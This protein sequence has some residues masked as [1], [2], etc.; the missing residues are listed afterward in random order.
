M[1][2]LEPLAFLDLA[3]SAK[4]KRKQVCEIIKLLHISSILHG[5]YWL[6]RHAE[7]SAQIRSLNGR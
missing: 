5:A 7:L 1:I 4:R 6:Q 3:N 2:T